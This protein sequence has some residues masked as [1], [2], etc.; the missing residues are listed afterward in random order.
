[1]SSNANCV[2]LIV[3]VFRGSILYSL[4]IVH[5]ASAQ[6]AGW[7]PGTERWVEREMARVRE[8]ERE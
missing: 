2:V 3:N 1:M 5:C 4:H 6:M 7:Q 8:R